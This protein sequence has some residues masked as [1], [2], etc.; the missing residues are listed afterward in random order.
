MRLRFDIENSLLKTTEQDTN[1][2]LNQYAV[3]ALDN[4]NVAT[5]SHLFDPTFDQNILKNTHIK[6]QFK[7]RKNR[8][9]LATHAFFL[10]KELLTFIHLHNMVNLELQKMV[11]Y[12]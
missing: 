10:K 2:A 11:N 12:Y 7:I 3:V 9:R 1:K 4:N 8:I 6:I 5:F